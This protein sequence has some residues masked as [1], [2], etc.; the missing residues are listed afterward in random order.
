MVLCPEYISIIFAIPFVVRLLACFR[1]NIYI[2]GWFLNW[3]DL[4]VWPVIN[5]STGEGSLLALNYYTPNMTFYWVDLKTA[6]GTLCKPQRHNRPFH[7]WHFISNWS[8]ARLVSNILIAWWPVWPSTSLPILSLSYGR[9]S[10]M[11]GEFL[12]LMA[13]LQYLACPCKEV[14]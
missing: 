12:Y 13:R 7:P 11:A 9:P 8:H 6:Q 5:V 14:H 1:L 3:N 10:R 2:L 4:C